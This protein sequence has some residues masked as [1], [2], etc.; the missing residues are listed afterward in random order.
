MAGC[1]PANCLSAAKAPNVDHSFY[2]KW[3]LGCLAPRPP[4][5]PRCSS[6]FFPICHCGAA[7]H[8]A[9]NG[10]S[11]IHRLASELDRWCGSNC[12]AGSHLYA[13]SRHTTDRRARHRRVASPRPDN[14]PDNYRC[15][16]NLGHS[17]DP[18]V[19]YASYRR[20][21]NLRPGNHRHETSSRSGHACGRRFASYRRSRSHHERGYG[22]PWRRPPTKSPR[23]CSIQQ[24]QRQ[25]RTLTLSR[26][27]PSA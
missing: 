24:R 25:R 19:G 27:L 22:N 14:C 5:N 16:A 18:Y 26:S 17:N 23:K 7:S 21:A 6:C 12:C 8:W 1:R 15:P 4:A 13:S 10:P 9:A 3:Y 20:G 11:A 2:S